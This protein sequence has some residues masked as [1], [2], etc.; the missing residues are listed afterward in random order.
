MGAGAWR[1]G[2]GTGSEVGC[3]WLAHHSALA[4]LTMDKPGTGCAEHLGLHQV[5][6]C[7]VSVHGGRGSKCWDS[8]R[9]G[10]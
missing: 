10:P 5:P 8:Q 3:L 2:L 6:L 7:D 9:E 4:E 1:G